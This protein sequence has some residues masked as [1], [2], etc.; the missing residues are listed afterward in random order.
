MS[1]SSR[2]KVLPLLLRSSLLARHAGETAA[3]TGRSCNSSASG[4]VAPV[5]TARYHPSPTRGVGAAAG[6]RWSS[7]YG[8][9]S[10]S[11]EAGESVASSQTSLGSEES[12]KG[13]PAFAFAFD[14]DGVLLHTSKPIPG[15][16]ETLKFL[17]RNNI[18]FILLTNGGGKSEAERVADLTSKLS[19]D[20]DVSNFVQSHT[21]YQKLLDP[22]AELGHPELEDYLK[23]SLGSKRFS[24]KET[25]L[26]LGSDASKARRIANG[27]GF[28]SVVTPGDILKACPEIFPFDPLREFYDKQEILPLPKPIYNP[29][30]DPAMRLEDCLK[31]DGIL[32]F[33]DPRDW[34]VDIQLITDL[35]LS[36]RGY[37]GTYSSKNGDPSLPAG[38][39]WQADGQPPL[40]FSNVDMQWSTGYHLSRL[41]QG[42]FRA[43]VRRV[44]QQLTPGWRPGNLKTFEFGKPWAATYAHAWATLEQHRLRLGNGPLE[45]VYMVGD[46]PESDIRGAHIWN[47]HG[48]STGAAQ[49]TA[50]GP[51]W[52]SCLVRTG[53]WKE[54]VAP[55]ERLGKA[56]T[57]YRVVDDVRAAVELALKEHKW[58]GGME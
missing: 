51:V 31:I 8:G 27:Y 17:Q 19:V 11:S 54:E 22:D 38:E 2:A 35:L 45:A 12:V 15:A 49:K 57:P 3:R 42:A 56:R 16:T 9:G 55:L 26:V 7:T 40:I 10:A 6:V 23:K 13:T 44:W 30:A 50:L 28:E 32:T 18:P 33:N 52:R 48:R 29:S 25:V 14:I 41:G 24:G 5:R 34:A 53:V 21:P 46:N 43:A 39:R 36:H 20:L 47:S 58:P 37:L 1:A 4:R